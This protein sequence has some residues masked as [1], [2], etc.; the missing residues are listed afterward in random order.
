[1]MSNIISTGISGRVLAQL[2]SQGL[3]IKV[4]LNIDLPDFP[5]DITEVADQELMMM[6]SR[7]IENINFLRTQV[8]CAG[9]AELEAENTYET[10]VNRGML[11]KSTGKSTEKPVLLRA[12]VHEEPE[13]QALQDAKQY[14]HAYKVLLENNLENIE[15]Y[16]SLTSRELT[17]RN[18]AARNIMNNRFIP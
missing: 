13:I 15:R 1:M 5:S 4:N 11:S 8:A 17:R 6:A 7:Y 3:P 14:A 12:L 10:A 18:S 16:Y 9:L 2:Q